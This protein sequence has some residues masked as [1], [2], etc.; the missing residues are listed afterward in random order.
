VEKVEKL[1][2]DLVTLDIE[3][4][5]MDGLTALRHIMKRRPVPVIMFSTLPTDGAEATLEALQL[6]AVDFIPKNLP[7]LMTGGANVR[8][9]FLQKIKLIARSKLGRESA[10]PDARR[11]LPSTSTSSAGKRDIF[12]E[13]DIVLIGCS[14]GG[15]QTLHKIIAQIPAGF[16]L[17]VIMV[18]HMPETFT[19]TLARRLDSGRVLTESAKWKTGSGFNREWFISPR[20]D[21]IWYCNGVAAM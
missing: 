16:E 17:P 18:Q 19:A 7:A 14:T 1:F 4:P 8:Q 12:A 11:P 10:K 6:G 9:M 5:V 2:P 13:K 15:A 3:M 20:G 21:I